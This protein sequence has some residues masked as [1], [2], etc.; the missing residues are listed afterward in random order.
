MDSPV[1]FDVWVFIQWTFTQWL[2]YSA[3]GLCLTINDLPQ[4]FWIRSYPSS[5]PT[6]GWR[7][8]SALLFNPSLEGEYMD[9]YISQGYKRYV[10]CKQ[11][12]LGFEL[13][14]TNPFTTALTIM[15]RASIYIHTYI[16]SNSIIFTDHCRPSQSYNH[17]TRTF[18]LMTHYLRD[19][20]RKSGH[21]YIRTYIHTN[22]PLYM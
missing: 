20:E 18:P 5:R 13:G 21:T 17:T 10:K 22:C 1:G 3:E 9:S 12:C 2:V 4:E 8:Q 7:A 15:P 6:K 16:H 11:P 19:H 14:S